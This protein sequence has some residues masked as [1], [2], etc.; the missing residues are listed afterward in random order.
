MK[1]LTQNILAGLED[2]LAYAK[3]DTSRGVKTTI[4]IP[5]IDVKSIRKKAGLTQEEF[6]QL[7]AIK[8]RTLQDWEQNRRKPEASARVF[9]LLIEQHPLTVKKVL[10]KSGYTATATKKSPSRVR[11]KTTNARKKTTPPSKQHQRKVITLKS[12][13]K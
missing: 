7:F 6:S 2:A 11:S 5:S 3:G 1:K 4:K 10:K 8:I 9:L 12:G 13:E